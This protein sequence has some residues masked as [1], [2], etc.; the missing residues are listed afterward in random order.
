MPIYLR[1]MDI[2]GPGPSTYMSGIIPAIITGYGPEERMADSIF[3]RV[4]LN[5][6]NDGLMIAASIFEKCDFSKAEVVVGIPEKPVA[7]AF[8][9]IFK[10]CRFFGKV[11]VLGYPLSLV[12]LADHSIQVHRPQD[13]TGPWEEVDP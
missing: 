7:Q 8:G 3:E 2:R 11:F 5:F 12:R 4:D 1:N 10:Q 13:L 6:G 9:C